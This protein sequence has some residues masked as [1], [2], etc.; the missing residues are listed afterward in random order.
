MPAAMA[1]AALV[2]VVFTAVALL[3][4]D[5]AGAARASAAPSASLYITA[6]QASTATA[7][8]GYVVLDPGCEPRPGQRAYP[9]P[10]LRYHEWMC[11]AFPQAHS[12]TFGTAYVVAAGTAHVRVSFRPDAP[13]PG[14]ACAYVNGSKVC[15]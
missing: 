11:N 13:P 7:R 15:A 5:D 12:T 3:T 9:R 10:P 8:A 2:V 14:P 6:L 4:S 1:V